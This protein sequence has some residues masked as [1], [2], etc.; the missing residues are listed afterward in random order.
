MKYFIIDWFNLIKRY[1]HSQD[2]SNLDEAEL[3]S[4]LAVNIVNRITDLIN[5]FKP[6]MVYICSDN[7]YNRRATAILK[8]YKSD[9]KRFKSLT[10]EEK[11]KNSIEYLKKIIYT[12]PFPFIEVKNTEADLIIHILTRYL[13]RLDDKAKFII[14]T[15]DSDF[16]QLLDKDTIIF[17]WYKGEITVENW[18]IKYKLDMQ[19][20]PHNYAVAKAI[21]G[22]KSDNIKGIYNWGWKKVSRLFNIIDTI[23]NDKVVINNINELNKV[24]ID[25]LN[26]YTNQLSSKD[27]KLLENFKVILSDNNNKKLIQSNQSVIDLSNLENPFIYKINSVITRETFEKKLK[28]DQK[29]FYRLLRLNIYKGNDTEYAQILQKN[30]KSSAILMHFSNKINQT[31]KSLNKMEVMS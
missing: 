26:N 20:N 30:A 12:L 6:D 5:E 31:I 14:A 18:C 10:D 27:K 3:I 15:S 2:I 16:I 29:E 24:I 13:R 21:V 8:D 4:G 9:R 25:I 7:G 22:D 11:E 28:Y 19:L 1:I 17:D 23:Y